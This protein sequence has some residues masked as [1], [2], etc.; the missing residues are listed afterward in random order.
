MKHHGYEDCGRCGCLR[1]AS[2][3]VPVT[4]VDGQRI[5]VTRE[6]REIVWCDQA[7]ASK[8]ERAARQT[9]AEDAR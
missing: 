5:A 9:A 3:L 4:R 6:C 2:S 7:I 1:P 8:A